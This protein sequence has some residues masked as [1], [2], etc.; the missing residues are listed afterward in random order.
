LNMFM[1]AIL[2]IIPQANFY[3]PRFRFGNTAFATLTYTPNQ[4]KWAVLGLNNR[5][6]WQNEEDE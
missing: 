1:Y 3:G 4:H 5:N 2:G 6:H